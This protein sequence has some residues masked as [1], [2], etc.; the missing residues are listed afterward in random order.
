[1]QEI[2]IIYSNR[3]T[4]SLEVDA[5]KGVVV[6]A[7]RRA[8]RKEIERFVASHEQ[9]ICRA[10]EKVRLREQNRPLYPESEAEIARLKAQAAQVLPARTAYY[11]ELLGVQ[12][13]KVGITRA[14]KRFGSCSGKNAINY[15]CFLMLYSPRAIDYVVVHELCHIRHKN[16]SRAF[17]AMI[18]SIMPDYKQ[19]EKELKGYDFSEVK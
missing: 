7:P 15:S 11:A 3:K 9:W 18:E 6:R 13:T 8:S 17:Y 10:Q 12:P 4:L 19:R 5:Q 16:H 2:K 14:K 1:M